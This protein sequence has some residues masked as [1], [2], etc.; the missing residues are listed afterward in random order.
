[1]KIKTLARVPSLALLVLLLNACGGPVVVESTLPE[2]PMPPGW[3][4]AVEQKGAVR[5]DPSWWRQFGS[6]ELS[7][8]VV[9]GQSSNFEIA[10]AMSRVRQAQVQARISGAP[11][12]PN[13]EFA[14]SG[15]HDF[16]MSSGVPNTTVSGMLQIGYEVD[17]WGRN[18]AGVS[19]AQAALRANIY[20]RETVDLTVTSGIVSTF[21]QVLS[22]RDRLTIARQNVSNT[23]RVLVLVESQ[24]R[25][26]AASP[27]DLA[28]QRS[29]VASQRAEIP[30]L[31]QQ[32]RDAQATLAILMGRPPQAFKVEEAGLAG[33]LMPRIAP[34]L[35]SELLAR[36]PD[37]RRAEALLLQANAN[38]A[39][40]RA[41]LFPRINLTGSTGA[42]SSALLALF[43]GPALLA[44]MGASIVAPIF[45]GGLLKNQRDL[46][47]EQEQE[48]V[49]VYRST[50]INALLEVDKALGAI[51]SL[52]Q[53]YQLKTQE[54]EQA[55]YAFGLSEIRYRN[56]AEDL[57]TV[58]DTQRSLADAQTQLGQI[59][60]QRLQATVSLYKALG[61]GWID[62]EAGK[63]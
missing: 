2:V 49:E 22:L 32:Q 34:G 15:S 38:V 10:A 28:R 55:R 17:F 16:P 25:A 58:L 4:G 41:A 52:E 56:G 44:N 60:L 33:I 6:T 14:G 45:D 23:E 8:L 19:A 12:L 27:L 30:D 61:G 39:V 59:K 63:L 54:M 13:V 47:K 35:P 9:A 5:P 40:A 53:R 11:L 26:G 57:M 50:V 42:Q 21:L 20:D 7:G 48:L 3:D 51:T 29:A 18:R 24:Q 43:N 62:N 36:R 1:M 37:V 31:I 46:A